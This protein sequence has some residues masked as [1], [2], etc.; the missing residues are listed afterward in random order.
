MDR[1]TC[2]WATS[3]RSTYARD[4]YIGNTSSTVG[5]YIKNTSPKGIDTEDTDMESACTKGFGVVQYLRIY[6]RFF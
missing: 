1:G 4:I 2:I 6:L 3:I 5:L